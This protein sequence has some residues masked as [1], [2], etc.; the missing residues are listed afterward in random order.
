VTALSDVKLLTLE[1]EQFLAAVT[2]QAETS[3]EADLVVSQRLAGLGRQV[4]AL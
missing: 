4:A 1:R 3:A 2:G